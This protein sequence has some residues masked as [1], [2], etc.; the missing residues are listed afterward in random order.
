MSLKLTRSVPAR[1]N[2]AA[3]LLAILGMI[4]QI[5]SGVKY[6]TVPPGIVLLGVAALLVTFVPWR[7]LR[8]LGVLVPLFILV[9][10]IIST[11][12]RTNLGHTDPFGPFIG[13][14]I[15]FAGLAIGVVAGLAAVLEWRTDR[16]RVGSGAHPRAKTVV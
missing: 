11:T 8:L 13:T 15:Q 3:L 14:V 9:G 10:G 2:A 5:A 7:P 4:V 1:I 12:G 6:P 16:T